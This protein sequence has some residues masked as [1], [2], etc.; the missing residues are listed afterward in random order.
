MQYGYNSVSNCIAAMAD[1]NG[2]VSVE[3]KSDVKDEPDSNVERTEDYPKLLEYGL[4]KRVATKLDEIY[5]TGEILLKKQ[6]PT[7]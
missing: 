3:G 7:S 4:D 2:E 1:G 6:N 5:K